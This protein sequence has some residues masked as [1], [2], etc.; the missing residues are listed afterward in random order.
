MIHPLRK[1]E[2]HADAAL[3]PAIAA[4]FEGENTIFQKFQQF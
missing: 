4:Y 1:V 3:F 2:R